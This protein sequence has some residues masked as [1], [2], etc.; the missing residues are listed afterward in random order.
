MT[1]EYVRLRKDMN[2]TDALA[3]IRRQGENAE[4][5]YTTY[6]VERNRLMGVASARS[7]LLA[8]PKAPITR[9]H[10]G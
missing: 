4:T 9:D 7:L 3:A 2:V 6:V 1:P 8:D 5:V 10:G